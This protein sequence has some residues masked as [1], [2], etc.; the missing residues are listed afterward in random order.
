MTEKEKEILWDK[1]APV[2]E[3]DKKLNNLLNC[4]S[5]MCHNS[6]I[7]YKM[8]SKQLKDYVIHSPIFSKLNIYS[9]DYAILE[10]VLERLSP[11]K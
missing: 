11:N 5:V 10:E 2:L 7:A 3:D 8:S 6:D 4:M 1:I 9:L